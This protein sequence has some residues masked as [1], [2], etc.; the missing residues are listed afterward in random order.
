MTDKDDER[1]PL[2]DVISVITCQSVSGL[3][4]VGE[5]QISSIGRGL[6][7]LLGISAEDTQKDADYM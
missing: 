4:A 6:C 5:E 7:V 1:V 3:L 2:C